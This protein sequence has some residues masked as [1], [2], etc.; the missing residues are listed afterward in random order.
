MYNR[1]IISFTNIQFKE[2]RYIKWTSKKIY[3]LKIYNIKHTLKINK[4][5][6]YILHTY[7][8]IS[9]VNKIRNKIYT[10]GKNV[11]KKLSLTE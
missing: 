2:N 8:I 10:K 4:L 9:K 5:S 6:I 1:V 11:W 3:K 7:G